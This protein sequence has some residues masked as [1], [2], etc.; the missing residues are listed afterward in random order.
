MHGTSP[1]TTTDDPSSESRHLGAEIALRIQPPIG[2]QFFFLP[3]Y[4]QNLVS[5]KHLIPILQLY[6]VKIAYH[7]L[8]AVMQS[9]DSQLKN[10]V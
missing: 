5:H 1:I 7:P 4:P 6:T 8:I 10:G 9:S 2:R 3:V